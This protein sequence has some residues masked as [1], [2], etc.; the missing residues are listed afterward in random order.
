MY[1]MCE[2][3]LSSFVRQI[4]RQLA[5]DMLEELWYLHV[6]TSSGQRHC[7][8]DGLQDGMQNRSLITTSS[9]VLWA[10]E[11]GCKSFVVLS[12]A[13]SHWRQLWDQWQPFVVSYD[14]PSEA[15]PLEICKQ[16]PSIQIFERTKASETSITYTFLSLSVLREFIDTNMWGYSFV[17]Y[18]VHDAYHC[19]FYD[20]LSHLL[21][22]CSCQQVLTYWTVSTGVL[23]VYIIGQ[24]IWAL[25]KDP[26]TGPKYLCHMLWSPL[27]PAMRN[28][29]GTCQYVTCEVTMT[30]YLPFNASEKT[31]FPL[32]TQFFSRGERIWT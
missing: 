8:Q 17:P 14:T 9:H 31:Y 24:A 23:V 27:Y 13:N 1:W 11:R 12:K 4:S 30:S 21:T 7:L 6:R 25:N 22:L 32:C 18:S 29:N 3:V 19:A 20:C 28:L 2:L 26:E 15:W 16:P 5:W 10:P